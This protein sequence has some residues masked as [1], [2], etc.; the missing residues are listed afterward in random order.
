M[1]MWVK[2]NLLGRGKGVKREGKKG[3]F[4]RGRLGTNQG[5]LFS[6]KIRTV[7]LRYTG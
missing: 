7:Y 6:P 1:I 2:K 3:K 4:I 5:G